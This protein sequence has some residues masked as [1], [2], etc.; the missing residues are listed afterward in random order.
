MTYIMHYRDQDS[1]REVQKDEARALIDTGSHRPGTPAATSA[2]A[3]PQ[4]L[5]E[6]SD[7]ALHTFDGR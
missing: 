6:W 4:K 1:P 5:Q 3:H 7:D 2:R